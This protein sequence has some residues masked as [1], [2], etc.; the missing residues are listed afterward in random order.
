MCPDKSKRADDQCSPVPVVVNTDT[1][2]DMGCRTINTINTS[3]DELP[4]EL[5]HSS[6]KTQPFLVFF[7]VFMCFA[8]ANITKL[9]PPLKNNDDNEY[10]YVGQSSAASGHVPSPRLLLDGWIVITIVALSFSSRW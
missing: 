4:P 7:W 2:I 5:W 1:D 6:L 3:S 9:A 10:E 8:I